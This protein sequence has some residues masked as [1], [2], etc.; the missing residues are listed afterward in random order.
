MTAPGKNYPGEKGFPTPNTTPGDTACRV[1]TFPAS[2]EWSGVL[3]GALQPLLNPYNWYKWGAISPDDAVDAWDAI[4]QASMANNSCSAVVPA[5]FWDDSTGDDADDQDPFGTEEWYGNWDGETFIESM[6]YWAVTAF[7]AS[8]ISEGAA[9][10]FITPLRKF[11]LTLKKS[12]HGA[13]LLVLMDSNIFQLVDLFS[14]ADEVV[15][16]DVVSPGSTLMLVHSGDHNPSATPDANGHYTVDIIRSRLAESDVVPD[17]IRINSST[18]KMQMTSDGGATW[19]DITDIDPRTSE[20]SRLA[21]LTP[22]TGLECDVAARMTAQL[23]D[24]LS[25][26]MSSVDAAQFATEALAIL[27]P[28]GGFWG[29]VYDAVVLVA[30]LLIDIG[31]AGISA[32]FTT[33]VYDDIQCILN[34]AVDTTGQISQ[35]RLDVAYDDI[36]AAHAG[37]VANVIDILRLLYGDTAMSNAG[38]IRTETGDCSSCDDCCDPAVAW[39]F[40]YDFTSESGL[41]TSRGGQ[42]HWVNG[43]GWVGAGTPNYTNSILK[44]LPSAVTWTHVRFEGS[45]DQGAGTGARGIWIGGTHVVSTPTGSGTQVYDWTGSISA[46]NVFANLDCTDMVTGNNTTWTRCVLEGIGCPFPTGGIPC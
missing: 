17:N 45:A 14:A 24:T 7:L 8:G 46:D 26:F 30:N 19:H 3:M 37:T 13:K 42:A 15:T 16:V 33:A 18:N 31:Q 1:F 21:A 10:E 34:C 40:T 28:L 43:Q 23:H 39:C 35:A 25:I 32:A 9:I 41:F 36:K 27:S 20:A 5:P 12:P 22:Y 44:T 29:Y 38:V 6:A 4:I 2:D 11:R